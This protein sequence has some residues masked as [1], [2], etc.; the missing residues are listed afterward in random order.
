MVR[1]GFAMILLLVG[2]APAAADLTFAV[3]MQRPSAPHPSVAVAWGWW[4]GTVGFEIE[5]AGSVGRASNSTPSTGS[6]SVNLLVRTPWRIGAGRVY[7]VGGIA[8]YGEQRPSGGVGAVEAIDLG[9][10]TTLRLAGPLHLRLDYRMFVLG[11]GEGRS[12][13]ALPQRLAAALS[14][15]F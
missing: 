7:A 12:K 14:L 11:R 15:S 2:V 1:A 8:A 4:P 13:S 9:A 6:A 5:Y 10:G 3:G